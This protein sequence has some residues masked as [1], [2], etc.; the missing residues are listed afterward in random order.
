MADNNSKDEKI[1]EKT[2]IQWLHMWQSDMGKLALQDFN[3]L[4]QGLL[5]KA[6]AQTDQNNANYLLRLAGGVGYV[7]DYV[8][9]T[10]KEAEELE[11]ELKTEDKAKH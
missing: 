5:Q 7:I 4:Q 8:L 2:K 6:M 3:E 10:C 9:A 1:D 11:K